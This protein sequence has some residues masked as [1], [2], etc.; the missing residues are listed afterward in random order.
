[1]KKLSTK[2]GYWCAGFMITVIGFCLL[3]MFALMF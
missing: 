2:I 1:M 3:V